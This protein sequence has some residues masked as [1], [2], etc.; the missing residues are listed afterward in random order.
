VRFD[1][2]QSGEALYDANDW[3]RAIFAI[4]PDKYPLSVIVEACARVIGQSLAI[5]VAA[6]ELE[7]DAISKSV[8]ESIMAMARRVVGGGE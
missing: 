3:S 8:V 2:D 5:A 6:N 4:L 7:G 1:F